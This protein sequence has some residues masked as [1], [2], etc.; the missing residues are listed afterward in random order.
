[1]DGLGT[2]DQIRQ[3]RGVDRFDFRNR[4]VVSH[5]IEQG[6]R[7]QGPADQGDVI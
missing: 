7:D 5:R 4:P 1:M 3:R 6:L 2:K